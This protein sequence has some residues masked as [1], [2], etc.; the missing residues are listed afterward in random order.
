MG[1]RFLLPRR[2]ILSLLAILL[3]AVWLGNAALTVWL[4]EA[5]TPELLRAMVGLGLAFYAIW[6]LAMVACFRPKQSLEWIAAEREI[7][8]SCPLRPRD[9]L[10]YKLASVATTTL[11]KALV[12]TLLLLPDL[13]S[14]PIALAGILLGMFFLELWRMGVEIAVWG[15]NRRGFLVF[16]AVM[17]TIL[18]GLGGTVVA[19]VVRSPL[20]QGEV[21]IGAGVMGQLGQL[22]IEL[23]TS[24]VGMVQY[25]FYP[26]A[27]MICMGE[28]NWAT[29]LSGGLAIGMVLFAGA[30]VFWLFATVPRLVACRERVAYREKGVGSLLPT[31]LLATLRVGARKKTP[32]P[33]F[34][35]GPAGAIA[36]RQWL[37]SRHYAGSLLTALV[38]PG[39]M[40]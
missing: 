8:E 36:W 19:T 18:A 7:L 3:A 40:A 32:D 38:I 28:L 26:F 22:L 9:L 25:P 16:R 21:R 29:T 34:P 10:A 4:R 17:I 33:F 15:M 20:L 13:R 39:L 2:L 27:D 35:R 30:L 23:D 5:A 31:R 12:L 6:H 11:L 14:L 37:G 24:T 1:R